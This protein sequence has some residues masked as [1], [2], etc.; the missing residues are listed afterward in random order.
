M[1][2]SLLCNYRTLRVNRKTKTT[3]HRCKMSFSR[4]HFFNTCN[5]ATLELDGSIT[6]NNKKL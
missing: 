4:E 6:V 5:F 1:N 3:L 2:V